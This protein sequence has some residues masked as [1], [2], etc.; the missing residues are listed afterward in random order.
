MQQQQKTRGGRLLLE[1][2]VGSVGLLF[3][4]Q[5]NRRIVLADVLLMWMQKIQMISGMIP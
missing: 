4:L 3:H 1:E 5:R 2:V